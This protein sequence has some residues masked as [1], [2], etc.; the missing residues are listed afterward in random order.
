MHILQ[1]QRPIWRLSILWKF[2][3]AFP[4]Y[5]KD[6]QTDSCSVLSQPLT[7]DNEVDVGDA[8][9]VIGLKGACVGPLVCDLHLVDVDWEVTAVTVGQCH[10]LVQRPLVCPCEQDV[11]AIQ[12]GLVGHLL[13]DPTSVRG[14]WSTCK[15]TVSHL[16]WLIL[17]TAARCFLNGQWHQWNKPTLIV[18]HFDDG[19]EC[20][21]S[22]EIQRLQTP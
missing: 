12:P 5:G 2:A 14:Q 20:C 6:F 22:N 18:W 3:F 13:V 4:G 15:S 10:A 16:V 21:W 11:R 17:N 9:L 7:V 1:A 8:G 19:G